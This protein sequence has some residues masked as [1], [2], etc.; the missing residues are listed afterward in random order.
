MN[1]LFR[2]VSLLVVLV[3]ILG[4]FIAPMSNTNQVSAQKEVPTFVVAPTEIPTVVPTEVPVVEPTPLP[5]TNEP[6]SDV[7]TDEI[8]V[9]PT[10]VVTQLPPEPTELAPLLEA[11]DDQVVPGQYIVVFKDGVDQKEAMATA[12]ASIAAAGDVVTQVYDTVLNGFAAQLSPAILAAFRADP[13]VEYIEEDQV[14]HADDE[15]DDPFEPQTIQSNPPSW[16]LDRVDQTALPLSLSYS[17]AATGGTG[18]TAYILDTGI[19]FDHQEFS[20]RAKSGYDFIDNDTNASDCYGHGTHVA[21]TIGGNTVGIARNVTLVSVRVLNCSNSWFLLTS[22][23]RH[24]L[25]RFAC[26]ETRRRKYESGRW[27]QSRYEHCGQERDCQRN[28]FCGF[29]RKC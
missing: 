20:G 3:M 4:F 21:G 19:R 27:I 7:P 14:V 12:S 23:C 16:G 1:K 28:H 9:E 17:Y 26:Q 8:P 11:A 5:G 2:F 13:R 22:H 18:V 10:E 24:Q 6:P 15:G 25:G 29:C